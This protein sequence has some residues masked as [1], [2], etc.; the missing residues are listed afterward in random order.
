MGGI[1]P[2]LDRPAAQP[3]WEVRDGRLTLHLHPGQSRVWRSE[4]RFI[5]MLSG[6]QGGKTSLGPHWLYREIQRCG[7][8]D[9]MAV[10]ST[11]P[12]L[13]L[14]MLPEFLCLF[15]DTLALGEWR[16]GDAVF[17][18]RDGKT[19]VIFGSAVNSESLE[20]ATAKAA[21]LDE[22]GQSQ[23]RLESWEAILRRL[24]LYQGRVLATTTPYCLGWLKQQVYDAW[25]AGDPDIEVVQFESTMNP[26]FPPEEME[27]ARRTMPAWKYNMFYRGRFDRPA[28]LIYSDFVDL[29]REEGGHKVRPFGIPPAWP[30]HVGIDFGAVNTAIVWLAH[31]T[32]RDVFYAYRC[33]LE[34]GKTTGQH[35]AAALAEAVGGNVLTWH[36]GSPSETQQRMDWRAAGVPVRDPPF[37]DV[38]AG[39]DRAIGLF[40]SS[41]LFVFDN[42]LG[43]LDEMGTYSRVVGEDG[44]PTERIK[45]KESFHR[46]DALRSVAIGITQSSPGVWW[47]DA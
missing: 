9:Y 25:R 17:M 43:L 33:T 14:K 10:T 8:G 7:P 42:L 1:I 13:K 22:A 47:L 11:Y 41:R 26:A 4:K 24:S 36:G 6:S 30:R 27:R 32:G 21:W 31:D 18:F 16:A 44:L 19:R 28:G 12:L 29:Y 3:L 15:Q 5:L 2:A 35:A 40:K 39:I 34:G 37:A 45:D 46:L 38:E 20:A 23:F